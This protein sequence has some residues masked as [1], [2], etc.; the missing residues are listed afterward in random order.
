[1][2]H[3]HQSANSSKKKIIN[4]RSVCAIKPERVKRLPV[5]VLMQTGNFN[6]LSFFINPHKSPCKSGICMVRKR[7]LLT[8]VVRQ[9][10]NFF[11]LKLYRD[12]KGWNNRQAIYFLQLRCSFVCF[13]HIGFAPIRFAIPIF[14]VKFYVPIAIII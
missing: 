11:I 6:F 1:M 14:I 2:K 12:T 10:N 8:T 13:V 3:L 7:K 9:I 5:R 4:R